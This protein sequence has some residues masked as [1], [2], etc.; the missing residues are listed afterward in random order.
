[1]SST[2]PSGKLLRFVK[3]LAVFYA[4][5]WF[6]L[7][8]AFLYSFIMVVWS[9]GSGK[10]KAYFAGSAVK[11]E[12]LLSLH[13]GVDIQVKTLP[14]SLSPPFCLSLFMAFLYSFIMVDW[15]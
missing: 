15:S 6:A 5:G 13:E 7:M 2:V 1:M 12:Q 14:R 8:M 11:I 4:G 3:Q 10:K 9:W